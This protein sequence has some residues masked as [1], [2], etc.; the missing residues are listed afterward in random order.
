MDQ[1]DGREM[2]ID[3]DNNIS[4][5]EQFRIK[6]IYLK[7]ADQELFTDKEI[8]EVVKNTNKFNLREKV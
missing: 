8:P 3:M 6:N 4:R 7:K 5:S 1:E 2:D